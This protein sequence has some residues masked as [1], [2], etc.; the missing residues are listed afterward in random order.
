[1]DKYLDEFEQETPEKPINW[2]EIFEKIII[3][4]KWFVLSALVAGVIGAV[5]SRMQSDVFEMKSSVL[6][7]DQAKSGNP[8]CKCLKL[9]MPD[10]STRA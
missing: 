9:W 1:M 7:I 8:G 10:K 3:N 5:Y 6:I 4:W 2:R